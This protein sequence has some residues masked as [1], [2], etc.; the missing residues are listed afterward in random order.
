MDL[1]APWHLL[2]LLLI[3][4]V[5]FGPRKLGD[6]GSVLGKTIKDFKSALNGVEHTNSIDGKVLEEKKV[7][8]PPE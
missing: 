6:L 3:V 5:I 1:F 8:V 7:V 4:L 2:M